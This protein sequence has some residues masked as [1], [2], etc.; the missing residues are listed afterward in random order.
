MHQQKFIVQIQPILQALSPKGLNALPKLLKDIKI[1]QDMSK[2][3][4]AYLIKTQGNLIRPVCKFCST[5]LIFRSFTKGY[6]TSCPKHCDGYKKELTIRRKTT[7]L[8]HNPGKSYSE[9][10]KQ[11]TQDAVFK[12]YGV[13]NIFQLETTKAKI[14]ATNLQRYGVE[15]P[16]KS[17]E[18][19]AKNKTSIKNTYEKHGLEIQKRKEQT[20]LQK[21]GVKSTNQLKEVKEK[22]RQTMLKKYGVESNFQRKEVKEIQITKQRKAAW[23]RLK[24]MAETNEVKP[25]FSKEEFFLQGTGYDTNYK[26]K[27]LKCGNE[28]ENFYYSYIPRCFKCHP[29]SISTGQE[30]LINFL[31]SLDIKNIEVNNRK[32]IAPQEIDIYLPDYNLGIEFN[33]TFWHSEKNGAN[34]NYHLNKLENMEKLGKRLIHIFECDWINHQEIIKARLKNILGFSSTIYARQC[35]IQ[36]ISTLQKDEFLEKYHLQGKDKSKIKLGLFYK[37][38]LVAVMTFGKPRFNKH[39]KWELIRFASIGRIIGGAS[40]LLKYFETKYKPDSIIS[41]AD[42]CWSVGNLYSKL[43]FTFLQNSEPGFFWRKDRNDKLNRLFSSKKLISKI[44]SNYNPILTLEQN[45]NINGFSKVYDC[46]NSVWV[47]IYK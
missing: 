10:I 5:P 19:A 13:K 41:Y 33:G 30:E 39:Y 3:E 12:K 18:I 37:N 47:K 21:Y 44:I 6:F 46:G 7:L 2:S 42:R 4:A 34:K 14:K 32:L 17:P 27:C 40:K 45:M 25:E 9:I 11:K 24:I 35:S 1:P 29:I 43:G 28:F 20:I 36:E 31:Q 26:W 23:D 16:Q 38:D 8:E 15:N 22:K